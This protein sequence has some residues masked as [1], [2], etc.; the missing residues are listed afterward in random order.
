[1]ILSTH[2][3]GLGEPP[4]HLVVDL[5]RTLESELVDVVAGGERLNTPKRAFSSLRA[6]TTCAS[7]QRFLSLTA[8]KLIRT[9][10]AMRV[11]SGMTTIGPFARAAAS[12]ARYV[13]TTSGL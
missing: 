8:A 4:R 10:K 7:T 5:L 12:K 6:R 13:A 1:M 9:W 11:F 2:G 3:I